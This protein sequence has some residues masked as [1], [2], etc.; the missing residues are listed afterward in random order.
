MSERTKR[1]AK[2]LGA[3]IIAQF[4]ETGGGAFGAARLR[5]RVAGLGRA[6]TRQ[7]QSPGEK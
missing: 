3:T 6:A 1:L 5:R 2:T 4:P 7:R